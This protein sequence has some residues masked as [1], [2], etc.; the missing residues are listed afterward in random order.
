MDTCEQA[1]KQAGCGYVSKLSVGF[2]E[3]ELCTLRS[4][5]V[6]KNESILLAQRR[7]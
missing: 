1:K 6:G 5:L 3:M 4:S 7:I 2:I